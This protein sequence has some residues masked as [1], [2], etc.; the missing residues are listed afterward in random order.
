MALVRGNEMSRD[1]ISGTSWWREIKS[2][3][4]RDSRDEYLREATK[5]EIISDLKEQVEYWKER[6]ASII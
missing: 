3:D 1:Y 5:D 6:S 2:Y 4:D